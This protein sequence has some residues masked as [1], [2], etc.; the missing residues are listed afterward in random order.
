MITDIQ[1]PYNDN[2]SKNIALLGYTG[3]GKTS[4]ITAA[5]FENIICGKDAFTQRFFQRIEEE[6]KRY[7]QIPLTMGEASTLSFI[8]PHSRNEFSI[9]DF[10]GEHIK[11]ERKKE[12]SY[13]DLIARA[14]NAHAVICMLS[15]INF[16]RSTRIHEEVDAVQTFV[17]ELRGLGTRI[18]VVV[19]LTKCD[20]VP[21]F[22]LNIPLIKTICAVLSNLPFLKLPPSRGLELTQRRFPHIFSGLDFKGKGPR[23]VFTGMSMPRLKGLRAWQWPRGLQ[24]LANLL[25]R[26][27]IDPKFLFHKNFQLE[28][29]FQFCFQAFQIGILRNLLVSHHQEAE[30]CQNL[31]A[32]FGQEMAEKESAGKFFYF[33]EYFDRIL[34]DTRSLIVEMQG[35]ISSLSENAGRLLTNERDLAQNLEVWLDTAAEKIRKFNKPWSEGARKSLETLRHDTLMQMRNRLAERITSTLAETGSNTFY[36][37]IDILRLRRD[38][39]K[40]PVWTN[41]QITLPEVESFQ[42]RLLEHF[43]RLTF[44]RPEISVALFQE[45]RNKYL[46][47]LTIEPPQELRMLDLAVEAGTTMQKNL[48]QR[49]V[50]VGDWRLQI[51][52]PCK[53]LEAA[54][55]DLSRRFDLSPACAFRSNIEKRILASLEKEALH[56]K[57]LTQILECAAETEQLLHCEGSATALHKVMEVAGQQSDT[58]RQKE[59]QELSA[60]A[61][62]WQGSGKQ[63]PSRLKEWFDESE[64]RRDYLKLIAGEKGSDSLDALHKQVFSEARDFLSQSLK[65]VGDDSRKK[66]AEA[67]GDRGAFMQIIEILHVVR[68]VEISDVF[69][70]YGLA[71]PTTSDL[72][73]TLFL[74]MVLLTLNRT[75]LT[76]SLYAEDKAMFLGALRGSEP[77]YLKSLD[78]LVAAFDALKKGSKE[79][80]AL[81][82]AEWETQILLPMRNFH[83]S[84]LELAGQFELT[85]GATVRVEAERMAVRTLQDRSA[86]LKLSQLRDWVA[87]LYVLLQ[88]SDYRDALDSLLHSTEGEIRSHFQ[89]DLEEF[90]TR[91]DN[92]DS[93]VRNLTTRHGVEVDQVWQRF[94]GS[95]QALAYSTEKFP[96]T[97]L[98]LDS[99]IQ[100]ILEKDAPERFKKSLE[101][102]L[103]YLGN[104]RLLN[105]RR[106]Q[107]VTTV[108]DK[109]RTIFHRPEAFL[110]LG[111]QLTNRLEQLGRRRQLWRRLSLVG[112]M[113]LG[114][115]AA[116]FGFRFYQWRQIQKLELFAK[117]HFDEHQEIASRWENFLRYPVLLLPL[118][119]EEI[120][121]KVTLHQQLFELEQM[122]DRLVKKNMRAEEVSALQKK[123]ENLLTSHTSP[124][125]RC[126]IDEVWL[127]LRS[128]ELMTL[129]DKPETSA[130]WLGQE[131][132]KLRVFA[133]KIHTSR[134]FFRCQ[135]LFEELDIAWQ[136]KSGEKK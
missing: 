125:V 62:K 73:K 41:E 134:P 64:K 61:K 28:E 105:R 3:V 38:I 66:I 49:E 133:Q 74:D 117:Q 113:L 96:H 101:A 95:V 51:L 82:I 2:Q 130:D 68:E 97:E 102:W 45:D 59:L 29:P 104:Y 13:Q 26:F 111:Q 127:G 136:Q 99:K 75:G 103:R 55:L 92:L 88:I 86:N 1:F 132:E 8:E 11:L 37:L 19:V 80:A 110:S 120:L 23:T 57:S 10:S 118:A 70:R 87:A 128:I 40:I 33:R 129:L 79:M 30:Y 100:N 126:K 131:I 72:E 4:F 7:G 50:G 106:C 71:L 135:P 21:R 54:W 43:I 53:K 63:L 15:A 93:V 27:W 85:Q 20:T 65:Q 112:L 16:Y 107:Q 124:E 81:P 115:V 56:F 98:S 91:C 35:E 39:A 42:Q 116:V 47:V 69:S 60:R 36:R 83:Q 46:E 44:S 12:K 22:Y 76:Q 58:L 121:G 67:K 114:V 31:I 109:A 9:Q 122:E 24:W 119:P 17:N 123:L 14:D 84:Y 32:K 18:P 94:A 78:T 108:L 5:Y 6:I 77:P 25:R 48:G 89:S 52:E 34:E 90:M